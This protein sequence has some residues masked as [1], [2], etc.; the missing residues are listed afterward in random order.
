[1]S[2]KIAIDH[3]MLEVE[4]LKNGIIVAQDIIVDLQNERESYKNLFEMQ[5]KAIIDLTREKDTLESELL[6]AK[7]LLQYIYENHLHGWISGKITSD[8][9]KF[10]TKK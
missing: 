2:S 8:V 4:S 6:K 5:D 9:D 10:L 1:M 7:K 3:L